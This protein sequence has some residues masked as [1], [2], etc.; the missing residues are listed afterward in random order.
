MVHTKTGD[1]HNTC[2][3][4]TVVKH[5]VLASFFAIAMASTPCFSQSAEDCHRILQD[6]TRDVIR[7]DMHGSSHEAIS[8]WLQHEHFEQ[9]LRSKSNNYSLTVPLGKTGLV[10]GGGANT[11]KDQLSELRTF[12][13]TGQNHFADE[14]WA[15][16][17]LQQVAN[18]DLIKAWSD[19]MGGAA[20]NRKGV[21]YGVLAHNSKELASI[22]LEYNII[23]GD[24]PCIIQDVR[25][26][27][28][29]LEGTHT[30]IGKEMN[31]SSIQVTIERSDLSPIFLHVQTSRGGTYVLAPVKSEWHGIETSQRSLEQ[32]HKRV[33]AIA[34]QIDEAH[35]Y[36]I[37]GEGDQSDRENDPRGRRRLVPLLAEHGYGE[38]E[39]RSKIDLVMSD[40]EDLKNLLRSSMAAWKH[41]IRRVNLGS[42]H[43]IASAQL[44]WI[45]DDWYLSISPR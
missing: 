22:H 28:G 2:M 26:Y 16:S 6:G 34:V 38:P 17:I 37:D 32:L 12:L 4:A 33:E 35:A 42:T 7:F 27:G 1:T 29:T 9:F 3:E 8:S 5:R 44:V 41:G 39:S 19:C 14:A 45:E 43:H 11:S 15:V 36:E 24:A 10:L 31:G 18:Q 40:K 23:M 30:L 20:R 25:V 13:S 21:P